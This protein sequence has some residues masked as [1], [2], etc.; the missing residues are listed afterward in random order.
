MSIE[1]NSTKATNTDVGAK[2]Q[3]WIQLAEVGTFRGHAA[4]PFELSTQVFSE[5]V[6]NFERYTLPIPI[7][8][9]HASESS[10]TE[11]TIPA[12]GAPAQGWINQL[13]NRGNAG[14]WGLVEWTDLARSYIKAGNYK[15]LSPA[16]RFKSRDRIT[17]EP[18]GARLTSAAMTNQ[19]FLPFLK[20]L[21]AKD[22]A[23]TNLNSGEP[24][25]ASDRTM[26][27]S[28]YSEHET[29]PKV[30]QALKLGA[31]A[32]PAECMSELGRIREM[33]MSAG[34]DGMHTGVNLDDYTGALK[35]MFPMSMDS[36]WDDLFDAVEELIGAS[37]D[38]DSDSQDVVE[39]S[40]TGDNDS[41]A[42]D[43]ADINPSETVAMSQDNKD[44]AA[45][46]ELTLKLKDAEVKANEA[47]LL[48][49]AKDARVAEL[50]QENKSLK[51]IQEKRLMADREAEVTEAIE[52]WGDKRG[53]GKDD[54]P[55][56]MSFLAS[57]PE[58]FRKLYPRVTADKRHLLGNVAV[59][60]G[61]EPPP[62]K[63]PQINASDSHGS[64]SGELRT[65]TS[66]FQAE[67]LSFE[68][69]CVKA[70]DTIRR[71]RIG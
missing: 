26:A 1:D 9:E 3:V 34:P 12:M 67:G 32:L 65:L 63:T 16:I 70:S 43:M 49:K 8:F 20:P 53:V 22:R 50:E 69:S 38:D 17:G 64:N 56:L 23:A 58:G 24:L 45:T 37:M 59:G 33:C 19:P 55:A 52:T 41:L 60:A 25:A 47:T 29:M 21:A 61:K 51:D 39:N 5:I 30:R 15:F 44:V 40:D 10:P 54:A 2:R 14:L 68:E 66:K 7:D 35:A 27:S 13:D 48:I 71:H 11:G 46:A 28:L 62:A 57:S 36:T 6:R 42:A 18:V 31:T 4:G